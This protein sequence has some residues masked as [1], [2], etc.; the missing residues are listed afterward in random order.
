[1]CVCVC[2]CTR[3]LPTEKVTPTKKA[4]QKERRTNKHNKAIAQVQYEPLSYPFI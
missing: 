2:V 1:M 4:L 3:P